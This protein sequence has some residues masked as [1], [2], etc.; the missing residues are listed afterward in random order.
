VLATAV[1]GGFFSAKTS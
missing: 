1:N